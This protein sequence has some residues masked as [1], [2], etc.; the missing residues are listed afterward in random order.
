MDATL[1]N[2]VESASREAWADI[3]EIQPTREVITVREDEPA[4][5]LGIA[6]QFAVCER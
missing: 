1:G 4:A 2:E 3:G 6:L 5:Q